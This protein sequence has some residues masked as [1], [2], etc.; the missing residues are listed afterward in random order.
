MLDRNTFLTRF[1]SSDPN[2]RVLRRLH[3]LATADEAW[4]ASNGLEWLEDLVQWLFERGEA[5][6]PLPGEKEIDTRTRLLITA[7]EEL[8]PFAENLRAVMMRALMGGSATLLFTDTGVPSNFGFWGELMERFSENFL[9]AHPVGREV[10]RLLGRLIDTDERAEWVLSMPAGTR[11]R[12]TTLLGLDSDAVKRALDP[13][14]RE[15]AILLASRIAMQGISDDLR[16]RMAGMAVASSP[17]LLLPEHVKGLL[18][19]ELS[20]APLQGTIVACRACLRDV[21]WS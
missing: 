8:P 7:A 16:K 12:L 1:G 19:G 14:L 13:G 6:G 21:Q 4:L 10:S 15:A 3:A 11:N 17:F 9:P 5:P 2:N 18:E 20:L